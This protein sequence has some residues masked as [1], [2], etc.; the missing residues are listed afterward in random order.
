MASPEKYRRLVKAIQGF[1]NFNFFVDLIVLSL[2]A[3]ISIAV[4]NK[5]LPKKLLDMDWFDLSWRTI[6]A[7]FFIFL[8]LLIT[9][10]RKE[11]KRRILS[12]FEQEAAIKAAR[13]NN[14]RKY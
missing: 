9:Q 1:D 3:T 7:C 11:R 10:L 13:K 12:A 14:F 2:F 8:V 5:F 6:G 4:A